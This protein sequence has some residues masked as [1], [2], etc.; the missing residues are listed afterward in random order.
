M[1]IYNS[2]F[3]LLL[4]NFVSGFRL[5]FIYIY[6]YV[7]IYIYI[8]IIVSIRSSLTHLHGFQ[9]PSLPYLPL[10][11]QEFVCQSSRLQVFATLPGFRLTESRYGCPFLLLFPL[12][13]HM[14]HMVYLFCSFLD[15]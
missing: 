12:I 9:Q 13:S 2:V 7:Y 14:W 5:E 1:G 6:I 4:V 8:S 15:L 11:S 10:P 3:L